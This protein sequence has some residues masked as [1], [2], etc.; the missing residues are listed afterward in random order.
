MSELTMRHVTGGV[1]TVRDNGVIIEYRR[2][3]GEWAMCPHNTI[4]AARK[5][6]ASMGY[7]VVVS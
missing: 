6:F 5:F 4:N 7:V 1:V 2:G 3:D